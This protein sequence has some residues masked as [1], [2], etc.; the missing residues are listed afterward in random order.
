[1]DLLSL[2]DKA[3]LTNINLIMK[4]NRFLLLIL[5]SFSLTSCYKEP[6]TKGII[7]VFD[8]QGNTV[9]NVEVRLSQEDYSGVEQTYIENT[10]YSDERGQ[11]EHVLENEAIMNIDAVLYDANNLD[12]LYYGPS[13]IRLVY[14]KTIYKNVQLLPF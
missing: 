10:Q 4:S 3:N 6:L 11:S 8:E 14:G 12:T 1:L 13:T 9:S 7:T 5:L 2:F